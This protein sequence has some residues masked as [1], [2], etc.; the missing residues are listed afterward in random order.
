MHHL[1]FSFAKNFWGW[2]HQAP[3]QIPTPFCSG[4]FGTLACHLKRFDTP[5]LR[6]NGLYVNKMITVIIWPFL[7]TLLYSVQ[8]LWEFSLCPPS[9]VRQRWVLNMTSPNRSV[10]DFIHGFPH[11]HVLC[12]QILHYIVHTGLSLSSSALCSLHMSIQSRVGIM[13]SKTFSVCKGPQRHW[14]ALDLCLLCGQSIVTISCTE[15]CVH[16]H[17]Y[18]RDIFFIPNA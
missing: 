12:P 18:W 3:S 15:V 10:S 2:A 13:Y 9:G 14:K 16:I 5:T 1:R 8:S 7:L 6:S 11:I 17:A 4:A